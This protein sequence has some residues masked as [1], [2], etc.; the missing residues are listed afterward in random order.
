M[1]HIW[2]S[3]LGTEDEKAVIEHGID[4]T[5]YYD[6]VEWDLIRATAQKHI[7]KYPCCPDEP[8]NDVTFNITLRRKTL[9]YTINLIIPCVSLTILTILEFYLPSDCGEKISL[10]ISVLLSL[11]LFQ[12]LLMEIIPPTSITIPLVGKYILLTTFFVS[13]SVTLTVFILNVNFRSETSHEMPRWM[14]QLL[15]EFLPRYLWMERP[16]ADDNEGDVEYEQATG[17]LPNYEN[18]DKKK[19]RPLC[20]EES[21]NNLFNEVDF[22]TTFIGMENFD[23]AIYCKV[24]FVPN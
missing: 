23:T 4:L 10:C 18:L 2:H 1:M 22:K 7:V 5:A 15:L 11:S 19:F 24:L 17:D 12:L 6:S 3:R 8:Y 20:K 16:P 21:T 13:L 9:F 14:K